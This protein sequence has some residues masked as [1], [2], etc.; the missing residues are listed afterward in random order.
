MATEIERKYLVL[1]DGW[2][3]HADTG[4]RVRQGYLAG[5][6]RCSARVRVAGDH[7]SLNFKGMTLAVSRREF[8]YE[9]PLADAKE[10]LDHLC[11]GPLI[12]KVR[13]RV[14][15]GD[16]VWEID[17][18]E[19]DNAGLVVAEIE[20]TDPDESF[21]IPE[22]VGREVSD[23]ARYYNVCLID[24]PFCEWSDAERAGD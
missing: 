2:R 6:S 15:H 18:F 24:Y 3:E 1:D 8:E 13:Y 14:P 5:S 21:A 19:G 9:V 7:A 11:T 17:C 4:Q 22:W 16:H 10:M 20:L 12:E 23:K